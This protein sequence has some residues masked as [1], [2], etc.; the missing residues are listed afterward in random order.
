MIIS[1]NSITRLS[2][3]GVAVG[4]VWAVAGGLA[5]CYGTTL[6][7]PDFVHVNFGF[8]SVFAVHTLSTL[9]GPVDKWSLD[10]GAL[11][12]DFAFWFAGSVAILIGLVYLFR[13]A[14]VA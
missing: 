8:P 7:V 14:A 3:A 4:T 12:L 6:N 10:V 11:A 2:W 1:M 9:V 13:R 5:M